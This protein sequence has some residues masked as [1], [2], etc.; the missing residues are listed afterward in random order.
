MGGGHINGTAEYVYTPGYGLVW[1][2]APVLFSFGM[3]LSKYTYVPGYALVWTQTI[4]HIYELVIYITLESTFTRNSSLSIN[5]NFSKAPQ[6][7]LL[8]SSSV[9]FFF[10]LLSVDYDL[11]I[12]YN[13]YEY[14]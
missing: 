10:L 9:I 13:D 1:T 6:R 14:G 4:V 8:L 2:Q 7:I 5:L 12:L 11:F 3:A